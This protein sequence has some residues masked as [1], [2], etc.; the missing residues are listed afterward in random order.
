MEDR[1]DGPGGDAQGRKHTDCADRFLRPSRAHFSAA[2]TE[3]A[4]GA[5]AS[6]GWR[7]ARLRIAPR[8]TRRPTGT[9]NIVTSGLDPESRQ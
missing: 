8:P 6:V 3:N 4:E 9:G 5:S 1:G 7:N 2:S